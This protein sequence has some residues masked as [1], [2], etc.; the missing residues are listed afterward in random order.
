[1]TVQTVFVSIRSISAILMAVSLSESR[2]N[3]STPIGSSNR[4]WSLMSP[5]RSSVR[6]VSLRTS[7]FQSY[8][9][10]QRQLWGYWS[11]TWQHVPARAYDADFQVSWGRC[12]FFL[13]STRVFVFFFFL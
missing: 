2:G 11:N 1:M 3:L 9:L 12:L 6:P 7:S 8:D 13:S 4:I 5:R 10:S